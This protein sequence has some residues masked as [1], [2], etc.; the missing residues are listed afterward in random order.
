MSVSAERKE[1]YSRLKTHSAAP[2]WEV[3]S[4]IVRKDPRTAV[5]A[6]LWRYDEMRPFITEAGRIITA[7]EAERRVLIL[8]NPGLP[9]MSRITQSLYAGLQLILP[10]EIGHTHRH[11]ASALRFILEGSG[12]YTSVDGER[13]TMKP[14]DFILTPFWS[15]HDH[16]NPG[17]EPVVWLDGLDIPTVNMFDTSFFEKH[18]EHEGHPNHEEH[19]ASAPEARFVETSVM[20]YPYEPHRDRLCAMAKSGE[21]DRR[22]GYQLEYRNAKTGTAVLPTIG[23]W[24]QLLP[25]GF[26][27][28]PSRATDATIYC[29]VEGRGTSRIGDMTFGWGPR[30]IF[31]APSW[32]AVSH[33][34]QEESVLFSFSD[35][36][37]QKALGIWREGV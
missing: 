12:A 33:Q 6:A 26:N 2:L 16:G 18:E 8:E 10:G 15:Y 36:P 34:A 4:D 22:Q 31:V 25:K 14:G 7:E 9:G 35:R 21:P 17:S 28:Q 13:L 30:D 1:F 3:L 37:A 32:H 11:T 27:S 19:D 23:A 20:K 29:A 5:Q 24:L